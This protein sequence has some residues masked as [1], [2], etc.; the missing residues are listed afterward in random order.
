MTTEAMKAAARFLSARKGCHEL[1]ITAED[2]ITRMPSTSANDTVVLAALIQRFASASHAD[3]SLV[4]E[5]L[6]EAQ[7]ALDEVR[8]YTEAELADFCRERMGEDRA[9]ELRAA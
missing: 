8:S 3:Y 6:E 4:I 5:C 9:D 7:S 1:A 2:A